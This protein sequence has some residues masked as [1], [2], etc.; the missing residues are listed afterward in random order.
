MFLPPCACAAGEDQ[1]AGRDGKPDF[2]C[3]DMPM[4]LAQLCAKHVSE[5]GRLQPGCIRIDQEEQGTPGQEART[6]PD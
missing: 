6:E 5:Y 4:E 3:V 1:A 2:L